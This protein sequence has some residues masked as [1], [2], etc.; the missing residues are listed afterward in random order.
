MYCEN[1]G[2]R[3]EVYTANC[4][5]ASN[6]GPFAGQ[7]DNAALI[8]ET[9]TLRMELARL[10]GFSNYAELSLATKMA[11]NTDQVMNFLEQ[12]A[13]RA[14]KQAQSEWRE[15]EAFAADQYG[16]HSIE[17]WDVSFYSEKLRQRRYQVSQEDIRPYPPVTR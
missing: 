3:E 14:K 10:L 4:T 11:E 8:E 15:L 9:L 12:L 6:E 7:W 17:A 1:R 16:V 5:R 13:D 2:L